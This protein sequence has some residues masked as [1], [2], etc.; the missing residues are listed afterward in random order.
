MSYFAM[1]NFII[2]TVP[3][4]QTNTT[5]N[6]SSFLFNILMFT[7]LTMKQKLWLLRSFY[8]SHICMRRTSELLLYVVISL[9]FVYNL[10]PLCYSGIHC[11]FLAISYKAHWF[12]FSITPWTLRLQNMVLIVLAIIIRRVFVWWP[13]FYSGKFLYICLVK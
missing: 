2:Y 13:L 5:D 9:S 6:N 1:S 10:N 11:T 8:T 4:E 12:L 3:R 7:S